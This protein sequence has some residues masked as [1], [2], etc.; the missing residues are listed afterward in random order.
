MSKKR[1]AILEALIDTCITCGLIT[2]EI[3]QL[4]QILCPTKKPVKICPEK[5][6]LKK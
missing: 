4:K 5:K 6:K 1:K 3:M 2:K